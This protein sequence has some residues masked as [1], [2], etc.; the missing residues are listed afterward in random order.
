MSVGD[1]G[2]ELFEAQCR[3]IAESA[4]AQY[5]Q[6]LS[7]MDTALQ[8]A[9]MRRNV[10]P[11]LTL[12]SGV[13]QYMG[14]AYFLRDRAR[15]RAAANALTSQSLALVETFALEPFV[16]VPDLCLS[17][18]G[19]PPRTRRALIQSVWKQT[20]S[21]QPRAT[22]WGSSLPSW[23]LLRTSIG[24]RQKPASTR[25]VMPVVS[26]GSTACRPGIC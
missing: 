15:L 3:D 11:V 4:I 6:L 26:D 20:P 18:T 22:I 5:E 7:R 13:I 1:Q 10:R 23:R 24:P 14:A 19:G 2:L 8:S 12:R 16:L 9:K 25:C 21:V 17:L